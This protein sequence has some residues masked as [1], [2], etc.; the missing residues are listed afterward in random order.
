MNT[1]ELLKE[2]REILSQVENLEWLANV[3]P[4]GRVP[5]NIHALIARIE[6]EPEPTV[7]AA[8]VTPASCEERAPPFFPEHRYEVIFY[9]PIA[10]QPG[11]PVAIIAP[12][13]ERA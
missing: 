8:N 7:L 12:E 10:I 3:V 2:L 4:P 5:G 9:L 1:T 13:E 6:A 11:E